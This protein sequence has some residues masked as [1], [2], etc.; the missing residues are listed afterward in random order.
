MIQKI[1]AVGIKFHLQR[2]FF[3]KSFDD[4]KIDRLIIDDHHLGF[5]GE[6]SIRFIGLLGWF[7]NFHPR[8]I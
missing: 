4:L 6:S 8:R 7:L 1:V 3:E 2:H 5:V